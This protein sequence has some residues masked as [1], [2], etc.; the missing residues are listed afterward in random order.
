MHNMAKKEF[1]DED[2]GIIRIPNSPFA[3]S[4]LYQRNVP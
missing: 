2:A 3:L 1:N 4:S